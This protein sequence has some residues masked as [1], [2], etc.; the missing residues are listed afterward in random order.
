MD[1]YLARSMP[2]LLAYEAQGL[3]LFLLDRALEGDKIIATF[4]KLSKNLNNCIHLPIRLRR[5]R[6][7]F[8]GTE[9][10]EKWALLLRYAER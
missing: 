3:L 10:A 5:G 6:E 1:N 7:L 2:H 8:S 4:G 9:A